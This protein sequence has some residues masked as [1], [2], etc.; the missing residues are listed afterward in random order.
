VL[1]S[2]SSTVV[3]MMDWIGRPRGYNGD[4]LEPVGEGKPLPFG[5]SLSATEFF[6]DTDRTR[7]SRDS[8]N[9]GGNLRPSFL[10]GVGSTT[11]LDIEADLVFLKVGEGGDGGPRVM[12]SVLEL[13]EERS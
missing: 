6:R 10:F 12:C 7:L 5:L 9:E 3:S 11:V 1:V 8:V 2:T 4:R 13:N